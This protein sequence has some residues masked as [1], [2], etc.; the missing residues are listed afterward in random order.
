MEKVENCLLKSGKLYGILSCE[1]CKTKRSTDA[2][3]P[4]CIIRTH[5]QFGKPCNPQQQKTSFS[6]SASQPNKQLLITHIT[7]QKSLFFTVVHNS[8]IQ[9]VLY[10]FTHTHAQKDEGIN[11]S[12]NTSL[13]RRL[14]DR[15][16]CPRTIFPTTLY[17]TSSRLYY[18]YSGTNKCQCHQSNS[19]IGSTYI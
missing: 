8:P 9:Q 15:G 18:N 4:F 3:E 2:A 7:N 12:S 5:F 10:F 13:S 19:R 14:L 1:H 16:F 6:L 11:S 17:A